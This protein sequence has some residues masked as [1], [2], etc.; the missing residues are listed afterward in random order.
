[1]S[2][3]ILVGLQYG[4][5]GKGKVAD[6]IAANYSAVVRFNGG[7]N[8]GHTVQ[9]G[10]TK[11]K[12]HSLPSGIA[13]ENVVNIIGRGCVINPE[14]LISEIRSVQFALNRPITSKQLLISKDCTVILP[15]YINTDKE[16]SKSTIGTTGKG[17]G[18]TYAAKHFRSAKKLSD[19]IYE[20]PLLSLYMGDAEDRVAMEIIAGNDVLAEGAQ[21]TWLDIDHGTYP[22]VTSS[23]TLASHAC[24][25]LGVG[26]D[27][28]RNVI[29]VFKAYT[30]RVGVGHLDCE[31]SQTDPALS[32]IFA[33][34]IGTTTQ[35]QRRCGPLNIPK[36][37]KAIF[38]NGVNQ[39]V[40]TKSDLLNGVDFHVIDSAESDSLKCIEPW[41][42]PTLEDDN[43]Y[44]FITLLE[45]TLR[46]PITAVSTGPNRLDY[47]FNRLSSLA[48]V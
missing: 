9:F 6:S 13:H 19:V 45:N 41:E 31:W 17:I 32:N 33:N 11:L 2:L 46:C 20:Y 22:Y 44:R 15:E 48:V 26:L 47:D 5:E 18:P 28:V 42:L 4:D 3:D 12:L 29:G 37:Q 43:F 25:T 27:K 10:Q 1:M 21:G 23:N 30:T 34:E 40:I 14:E 8:A 24:T 35:R 7:N 36:M 38:M 39:L 16:D